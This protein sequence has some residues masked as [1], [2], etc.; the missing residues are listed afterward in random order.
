MANI[1]PRK[2]KNG[3]I[4]S[5][6]IRVA[7][8][9][10]CN[11][12]QLQPYSMT[13][14]PEPNMT[15]KQ[16][17]KELNRQATLF[18]EKCKEG[19]AGDGRQ[20]FQEYAEYV[21]RIK[22][23]SGEL[24]HHTVVRYNA[25]LKRI[26]AGIGHIRLCDLRPQHINMLY[27]QLGKSGLRENTDKATLKKD[28]DL[29]SMVHSLPDFHTPIE[30]YLKEHNSVGVG[31]FRACCRGETVTQQTAQRIADLLG[32]KVKDLFG[33]TSDSRPLSQKTIRE[34]YVIIRMVLQQA[35]KEGLVPYNVAD[36]TTPPKPERAEVNYF[37][38]ETINEIL[39]CAEHEPLKWK[40]ILHLLLVTGGRRGEVLGLSWDCVDF[41]FNRI[42]INKAVYYQAD[43][44]TYVDKPKT[45]TSVRFIK[46]PEES[47]KL[48]K[49]YRDE[50]YIPLKKAVGK[51]WTG[52]ETEFLFVQD[53]GKNIG[54][55]MN[56]DSV[57]DYCNKFSKKYNL[58]HI[59][60]HAFRHSV[61]SILYFNGMDSISISSYLG[62][63]SPTTTETIYA[64]VL[65]SAENKIANALGDVLITSHAS[66]K[67]MEEKDGKKTG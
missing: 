11:G 1:T 29:K 39:Q 41:T 9:Y 42:Y 20:K 32:K 43:C 13:W 7:R 35:L 49:Q 53:S 50:Y 17:E 47:M 19:L 21:I 38:Q 26:N 67:D 58:P 55:P 27:E 64:H 61:A 15:K 51:A 31:T 22:T 10:D 4:V 56:P 30:N 14:K 48:L 12:K 60:P 28:I 62:H 45:K 34:H 36:R 16:I 63:A 6:R 40:V 33:L 37:E 25:L 66:R 52:G 5:Y 3:E 24:R 18:E 59:N 46:L 23:E 54:K 8:G 44:G 2:N 57:T 65:A